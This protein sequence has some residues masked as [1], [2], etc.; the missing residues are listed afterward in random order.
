MTMELETPKNL[1]QI[2]MADKRN[3]IYIE[4]YVVTY[5]KQIA[6]DK[7]RKKGIAGLFGSCRETDGYREFYIYG[8]AFEEDGEE[9]I[10]IRRDC[11]QKIMRKRAETFEDYFFL[12]W[13]VIHGGET[14]AVWENFYRSRMDSLF[15]L[16]EILL[17]IE[18]DTLE[19]HFYTYPTDMPKE[20]D[21]YFIFYEQNERMQDFMVEGHW[22]ED[23]VRAC[24]PDDVAKTCRDFYKEKREKKKRGRLAIASCTALVLLMI[25]ALGSRMNRAIES[26]ADVEQETVYAEN[27]IEETG[28]REQDDVVKEAPE[29][30]TAAD[31]SVMGNDG[32]ESE[33]E[34]KADSE[35][36][37]WEVSDIEEKSIG[38][39]AAD[40]ETQGDNFEQE[41]S[42]LRTGG[43]DSK[44]KDVGVAEKV[45]A[46]AE[47]TLVREEDCAAYVVVKGDTLYGICI[48]FYGDATLLEEICRINKIKDMNN[49]LCGQK[50]LLPKQNM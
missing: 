37:E 48:S 26:N 30:R 40:M 41:A 39:T 38:E 43:D 4:D 28:I 14:G 47:V 17:T 1:K 35:R 50:I 8:A 21:G 45:N 23:V 7:E 11:V 31:S 29:A 15:G 44:V 19:E 27:V 18:K 3:K 24:E 16:P 9:A 6:S 49:I 5:L 2:G 25:F 42:D 46:K 36:S 22:K 33:F 20:T 10:A 32:T 12:G 13:C 34:V